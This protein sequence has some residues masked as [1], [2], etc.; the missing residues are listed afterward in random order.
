MAKKE[1]D[2][3]K[4]LDKGRFT[5]Y[6]KEQGFKGP[7]PECAEKA[8]KSKNKSVRGEAAFY[9]NTVLKK[10]AAMADIIRDMALIA[11]AWE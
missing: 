6:C 8:L 5:K 4:H 3:P 2:W 1:K 7:C 11:S 10:N 9:L